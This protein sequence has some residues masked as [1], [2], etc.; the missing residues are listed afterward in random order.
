LDEKQEQAA[1]WYLAMSAAMRK[2]EGALAGVARW[3]EKVNEAEAEIKALMALDA[4]QLTEQDPEIPRV[5]VGEPLHLP[6]NPPVIHE[7]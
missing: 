7:D 6:D 4:P 5:P 2:R 1:D 3:Q